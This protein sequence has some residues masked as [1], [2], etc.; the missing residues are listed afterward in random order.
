MYAS[1]FRAKTMKE[2]DSI[3]RRGLFYR[4]TYRVYVYM[5]VCVFGSSDFL[6]EMCALCVYIIQ[7]AALSLRE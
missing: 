3:V 6:A 4:E 1:V 7:T 5:C 2:V